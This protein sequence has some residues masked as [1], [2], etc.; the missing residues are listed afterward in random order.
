MRAHEITTVSR[1]YR[2]RIEIMLLP[3][4]MACF[5]AY[6]QCVQAAIARHDTRRIILIPNE[7]AVLDKIAADR[8]AAALLTQLN[9]LLRLETSLQ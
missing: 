5:A 7:Q 1:Q 9:I 4:D 3:E 6:Q 2:N 8:P